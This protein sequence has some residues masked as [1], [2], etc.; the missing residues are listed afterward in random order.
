ML[1]QVC[2]MTIRVK[3]LKESVHFYT[4]VLGFELSQQYGESIVSLKHPN[5]PLILE[6]HKDLDVQSQ[7]NIVL[8]IK[9]ENLVEDIEQLKTNGVHFAFQNPEP[10]PPG[11]YNVFKDPSGNQIELIEFSKVR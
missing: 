8:A 9:S 1:D 7:N 11:L 6:E 4:E 10:C 5:I 2:V 3:N